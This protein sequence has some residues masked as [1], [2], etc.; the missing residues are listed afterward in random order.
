MDN[1]VPSTTPTESPRPER[2]DLDSWRGDIREQP[3]RWRRRPKAERVKSLWNATR[4]LL[5]RIGE[6]TTWV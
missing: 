4:P 2:P 3:P 1:T 5:A 6:G